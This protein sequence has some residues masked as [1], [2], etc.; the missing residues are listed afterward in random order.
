[1]IPEQEKLIKFY[2]DRLKKVKVAHNPNNH[3]S[4]ILKEKCKEY[5]KLA[6]QSLKKVKQGRNW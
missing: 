3:T 5:I 2:T 6:K 1:M 4:T